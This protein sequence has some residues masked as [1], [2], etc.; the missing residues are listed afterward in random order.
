MKTHQFK[1]PV[2]VLAISLFTIPGMSNCGQNDNAKK[3]DVITEPVKKDVGTPV[4][5]NDSQA[6]VPVS[7]VNIEK[8]ANTP[9]EVKTEPKKEIVSVDKTKV[10]V[11]DK[12]PPVVPPVVTN[13]KPA[14]N[15]NVTPPIDKKPEPPE[16]KPVVK[17]T[18]PVKP[19]PETE[20]KPVEVI[21]P[22]VVVNPQPGPGD[23]IV[24]AKY[25]TMTSPY[26]HNQEALDLGKTLYVTHCKSCH[27]SKG[28]GKGPKAAQLDTEMRSF[29]TSEFRAQK[30]GEVY[31]KTVFGRKDMPKFENK[32]ADDEERWAVVYYILNLK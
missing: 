16:E 20:T 9:P 11:P 7:P 24:P 31:Y 30:P 17:E 28:D 4:V 18:E 3:A 2:I 19:K 26:A 27:G 21:K 32:I 1:I 6:S 15:T 10:P 5:S 22:P 13:N 23:W 8:P 25:K 29:L 14:P 12:K